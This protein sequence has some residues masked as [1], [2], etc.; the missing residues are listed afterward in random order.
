M[1]VFWYLNPLG[2]FCN[3]NICFKCIKKLEQRE[4]VH[5]FIVVH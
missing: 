5:L 2:I 3:V 1:H 4:V